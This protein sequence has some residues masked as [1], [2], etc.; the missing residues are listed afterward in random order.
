[1]KLN[2]FFKIRERGQASRML[3]ILAIVILVAAVIV[4]LIMKMAEKPSTPST[5][6]E[7]ETVDQPVYEQTLGN[8]KFIF[9]SAVDHGDTLYAVNAVNSDYYNRNENLTTTERFVEVKIGAKNMG[10]INMEKGS[11]DVGDIVDSEGREFVPVTTSATRAWLPE[12]DLCGELLKPAFNPTPCIKIY[13]VS[14]ESSGLK[15]RVV[16]GPDNSDD[17]DSDNAQTALIDL[18]VTD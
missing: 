9:E 2:K 6:P 11:W 1:M 5:N 8:I 13:E 4:F 15:I 16:T 12:D 18:I 3:L 10:K 7:E 14:R 17:L